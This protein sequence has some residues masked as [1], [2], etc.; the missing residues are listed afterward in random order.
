MSAW[1]EAV[2][3]VKQ[4]EGYLDLYNRVDELKNRLCIIDE[5][6]SQDEEIP[7]HYT[8]TKF[9]ENSLWLIKGD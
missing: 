7:A 6:K 8:N 2:Y 4:I 9:A 1:P 5:K 3:T